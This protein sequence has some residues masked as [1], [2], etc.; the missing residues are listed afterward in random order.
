MGKGTG[1]RYKNTCYKS[2]Y[3]KNTGVEI[4]AIPTPEMTGMKQGKCRDQAW[5]RQVVG[6]VWCWGKVA[7]GLCKGLRGTC[8]SKMWWATALV[9]IHL[10]VLLF[11]HLLHL[12]ITAFRIILVPWLCGGTSSCTTCCST[13]T[14]GSCFCLCLGDDLVLK[15]GTVVQVWNQPREIRPQVS[16]Q[17]AQRVMLLSRTEYPRRRYPSWGVVY[18]RGCQLGRP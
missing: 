3:C 11:S 13:H 14:L 12:H 5:M 17:T 7:L 2:R 18:S 1:G 9:H 6:L 8:G 16:G 10:L 4:P 15:A